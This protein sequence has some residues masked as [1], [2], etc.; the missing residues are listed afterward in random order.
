MMPVIGRWQTVG[1]VLNGLVLFAG[2]I[3]ALVAYAQ[4]GR[5]RVALLGAL[6]FLLMSILSCCSLGWTLVQRPLTRGLH[7]LSPRSLVWI[8]NAS[9]FGATLLGLVGLVL[10][11]SAIWTGSKRE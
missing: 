10:L 1:V 6:G 7:G 8:R 3:I 11:I 4:R 9:L 2:L 5:S